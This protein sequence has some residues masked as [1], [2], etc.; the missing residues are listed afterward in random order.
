[1][2]MVFRGEGTIVDAAKS[3]M[4]SPITTKKVKTE[5]S[6]ETIEYFNSIC[7][8]DIETS[9]FYAGDE[10]QNIMY[11][12]MLEI[13]GIQIIGRTWNEFLAEL[14]YLQAYCGLD[15]EH[16]IVIYVHNLA[17]EFQYLRKLLNWSEVFASDMRKVIYAVSGGFEFRCSFMLSGSSLANLTLTK[18][19][20]HK[21]VGDLDYSKIRHSRTHLTETEMGYCLGDVDVLSA[22]ID[23][24][25]DIYDRDITK[26]PM[27]NTGRVRQFFRDILM[28]GD[29]RYKSYKYKNFIKEH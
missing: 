29:N 12:Y 27:T 21:K 24:Q 18:H 5:D 2:V 25:M 26:I 7:A 22:Y 20:I 4:E 6:T 11:I 16:R 15:N 1:M 19:D 10:K 14:E 23:E 3:I 17:Y 9:S 28:P 8:F 13:N